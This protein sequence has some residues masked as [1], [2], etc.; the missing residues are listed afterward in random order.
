MQLGLAK[1]KIRSNWEQLDESK[2]SEL[3][4]V[5][6]RIMAQVLVEK[7][8]DTTLRAAREIVSA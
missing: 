7:G 2:Q 5:Y 8:E 6:A 1:V 3:K 4:V